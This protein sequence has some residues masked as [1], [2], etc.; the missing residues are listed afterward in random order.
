MI[1]GKFK[2]RF[3][4][5]FLANWATQKYDQACYEKDGHKIWD[6]FPVEDAEHLAIKA[7]ATWKIIFDD[8]I[9]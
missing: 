2:A 3:I 4:A 9:G 5:V 8:D 7:W 6:H 1:E